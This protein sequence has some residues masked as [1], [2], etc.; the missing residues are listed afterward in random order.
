MAGVSA[1]DLV[2]DAPTNGTAVLDRSL[3]P[4]SMYARWGGVP[5]N[6]RE[7]DDS[8]R[9]A[10]AS[11]GAFSFQQR[12]I[13]EALMAAIPH[14]LAIA[15]W[16]VGSCWVVAAVIYLCDADTTLV[17]PLVLV[18]A[19]TGAIEWLLASRRD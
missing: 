18:G 12:P 3:I 19:V 15:W 14:S 8:Y 10:C 17:G 6:R 2:R 7:A 4:D 1:A 11:V 13:P 9:D 5:H 16:I